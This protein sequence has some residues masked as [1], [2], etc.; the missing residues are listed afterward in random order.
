MSREWSSR[1][2]S[3]AVCA[4]AA[5]LVFVLSATMGADADIAGKKMVSRHTRHSYR[6]YVHLPAGYGES[7]RRHDV[8]YLLD[9]DRYFGDVVKALQERPDGA[10]ERDLIIVG[11]GYGERANHR[12]RDYTPVRVP[13]FPTGGGVKK[14]YRFLRT[15]LAP[16]ID[17]KY[18]TNRSEERRVGKEC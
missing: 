5:F 7:N 4:A 18:R 16:R 6:V 10:P 8:L 15:E 2:N 9:G 17:R 1:R 11:I 12:K 14:F 13:G 3:K